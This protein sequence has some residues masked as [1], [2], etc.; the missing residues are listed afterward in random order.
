MEDARP[1]QPLAAPGSAAARVVPNTAPVANAETAPR[2]NVWREMPLSKGK[3]SGRP[4]FV[5]MG[6][7]LD[8]FAPEI[9]V[10]SP[11]SDHS[12]ASMRPRWPGPALAHNRRAGR[13]ALM[14]RL[15]RKALSHRVVNVT[16]IDQ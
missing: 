4:R 5:V 11:V 9:P 10:S 1:P 2:R 12:V 6:R 3:A 8:H 14:K 13:A 15:L 16:V 7:S